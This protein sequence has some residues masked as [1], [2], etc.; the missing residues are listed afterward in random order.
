MISEY[1]QSAQISLR[2]TLFQKKNDDFGC[3][4]GILKRSSEDEA[5][6]KGNQ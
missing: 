2:Y 5:F 6:S 4:W 1:T 3:L